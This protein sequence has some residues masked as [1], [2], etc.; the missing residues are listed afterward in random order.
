MQVFSQPMKVHFEHSAPY[1]WLN[2]EVLES[3]LLDDMEALDHWI[4]FTTGAQQIVDARLDDRVGEA[5]Q[6]IT[7]VT[8]THERS[9]DNS[10][11]LRMQMP[12][13]LNVPGP[14]SG[15]GWGTAGVRREFDHEDWT[16]SNRISIWIY[17]DNPGFYVNWME[18]RLFN[19]GVEKLPALF[20]QEGETTLMLRNHEWN[21]VVWEISN[22]ARDQVTSLEISYYL[23]GNEPE[24][25]DT[26]TFYIDQLELQTVEPDH[27]EGWNVW[28]GRISF[29]H[30]GYQS[31]AVKTAIANDLDASEFNVINQETGETVLS[32]SLEMVN[33]HLGTYQVMDFSEVWRPGK[34]ILESGNVR[35]NTFHIGTDVWRESILKALNFFYMER[36][37]YPIPGAHGICHRDWI[38]HHDDKQIVV[39]GGWH[40]AGDLTQG[41]TH[42]GEAIYVMFNL[43]ERLKARNEDKELYDRLVEEAKWGLDWLL[44]TSFRDGY[45][46][47][48]SANSRKTNGI[49]GDFDDVN[50]T[51][52]N[53]PLDHLLASAS[54]AIAYNILSEDDPRLAKLSL[55]MAQEDWRFAI[56]GLAEQKPPG[57]QPIFR[58]T[59]DPGYVEHDIAYTGILAAIE[60]WKATNKQVYMEKAFEWA[61]V[62]VHSQQ[63]T[64]PDWDIPFTGFFYTG[65]KKEQILHYVHRG[66]EQ[67]PVLALTRLCELLPDHPEWMSWYSCVVLHSE[68]QKKISKYTAPYTVMPA[69]IYTDQEY[70]M[71]PESRRESFKRQVLNGIPLGK[72]H[73]LR[74]FPVWLDY[75][76]NFAVILSQAQAQIY[77][78]KLRG[79]IEA[80]QLAQ[81]QQEWV[82]GRNPF[83]QSTMY[84]EGYDFAPQYSVMSGDMVGGLPVGI[85]TRGDSDVPY[86]PVQNTW[87]YKEIWTRPVI[88][89]IWLMR[90]MAGPVDVAV[91]ADDPV[92]MV[93]QTT[94]QKILVNKNG[95]S[96]LFKLNIPEGNYE[97]KYKNELFNRTFLPAST[98]N[99][100][101]SP[102]KIRNIK[103]S[104]STTGKDNLIIKVEAMGSG[105]HTFKIRTDNLTLSRPEKTV[106]L[107]NG[108]NG[109]FEWRCRITN[110]EIPWIAVIIPDNDHSLR[111][112]IYGTTW[113]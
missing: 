8:L 107:E 37:G 7:D 71:A 94:G 104:S 26:A 40:D 101:M 42:T 68:Y 22:V 108:V 52:R 28:P 39:N 95:S 90:D 18:L 85:Q 56:E 79:D 77:A 58:G 73:Y 2:K 83:S 45:R 27:I 105:N 36:C 60:L 70:L 93:N 33:S 91:N 106:K 38:C 78:G 46:F 88:R 82:V 49:I 110:P 65:T 59:F 30:S 34:Y 109:I 96:G 102:G 44:K 75:R 86:W 111:K 53:V 4:P 41:I 25:S 92:E 113:E 87:T 9:R 54:E 14:R 64:K 80:A 3:R 35:T 29:S 5:N 6:I 31:G 15:R 43:A 112:D 63:R 17:P 32:K 16:E 21:H 13:K 103:V 11:S 55:K 76:G 48:G 61:Q 98:Y 62:I 19:D 12:T 50:A 51:A 24:A 74:L 72:G 97:I 10:Q 67:G 57:E 99:L 81:H 84:G 69:S 47:G 89:W 1:R 66:N 100:D 23:S 20:G